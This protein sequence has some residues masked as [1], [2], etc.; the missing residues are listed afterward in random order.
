MILKHSQILY[1][2]FFHPASNHKKPLIKESEWIL[3]LTFVTQLLST[4]GL[5][6]PLLLLYEYWLMCSCWFCPHLY[7]NKY[8]ILKWEDLHQCRS[9]TRDTA[10]RLSIIG[11]IKSIHMSAKTCPE[12]MGKALRT[13]QQ[14]WKKKQSSLWDE[15]WPD[16]AQHHGK[17]SAAQ[18]IFPSSEFWRT[19]EL[20]SWPDECVSPKQRLQLW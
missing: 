9:G 2:T 15:V 13:V 17:Y 1:Q 6:L 20:L 10:I 4:T 16:M 5:C 3:Q 19:E 11:Q 14:E 8:L 12:H 18:E 7:C